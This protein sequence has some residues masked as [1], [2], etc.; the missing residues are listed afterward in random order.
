M[1]FINTDLPEP[2]FGKKMYRDPEGKVLGGVS[3]GIATYF[4]IDILVQ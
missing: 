2:D 4:N 1:H 3:G